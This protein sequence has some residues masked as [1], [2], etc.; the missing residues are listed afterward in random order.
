MVFAGCVGSVAYQPSLPAGLRRRRLLPVDECTVQDGT[1]YPAVRL[2]LPYQVQYGNG[3]YRRTS[4][5]F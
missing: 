2:P 3:A 5:G 1:G 4:L